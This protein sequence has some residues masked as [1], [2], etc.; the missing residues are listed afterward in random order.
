MDISDSA[1]PHPNDILFLELADIVGRDNVLAHEPMALH[2]TFKV[3]GPAQFFVIPEG[4]NQVTELLDYLD[5]K[6]V[7]YFVLGRGSN[8]VVSDEGF[9][10]IVVDLTQG[11]TDVEVSGNELTAQAGVSLVDLAEMAA[12]LSL[13]GLEFAC[14][15]PGTVGGAVFMNAGAYDG[16]IAEIIKSARVRFPDGTVKNLTAK[17]L[18]FDY[19]MSK[20]RKENLCVL[21]AMFELVPCDAE[22]IRAKMEDFTKRR[23]TKQPLE[24]P[25]AG[26]A[27]KRPVGYFAGKLISDAGLSGFRIGGIQI[28]EKHNGFIV[29]VGDGT[30]SQIRQVIQHVQKEVHN[31]FGVDLETEIQFLGF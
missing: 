9:P 7:P 14:G 20:V 11:L 8:L 18:E 31:Q 30:A 23:E 21:S 3:G 28:S 24:L 2:T 17:E 15:I 27:F 10:G 29:N 4:V 16:S 1:P 13:S 26:S 12:A 22:K 5:Y 25:S 19:R 6:A